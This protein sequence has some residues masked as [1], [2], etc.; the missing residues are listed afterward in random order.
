MKGLNLAKMLYTG[1]AGGSALAGREPDAV[2]MALEKRF[3]VGFRYPHVRGVDQEAMCYDRTGL[4]L[5]VQYW[6]GRN[7]AWH[8]EPLAVRKAERLRA[9]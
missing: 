2:I 6:Q 9:A 8:Y 3:V 5:R 7:G 4:R 1:Y